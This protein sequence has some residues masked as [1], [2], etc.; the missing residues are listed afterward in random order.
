MNSETLLL[1]LDVLKGPQK[2]ETDKYE[3][4]ETIFYVTLP[5]ISFLLPVK[6]GFDRTNSFQFVNKSILEV[7]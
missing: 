7:L 6:D 1:S 4:K 5:E 2:V 3:F